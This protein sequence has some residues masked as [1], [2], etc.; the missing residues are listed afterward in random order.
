MLNTM[1]IPSMQKKG[2]RRAS[3]AITMTRS[4]N[5]TQPNRKHT[6]KRPLSAQPVNRAAVCYTDKGNAR[7]L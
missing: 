1:A 2:A 7:A 3:P 6:N 5:K 4:L